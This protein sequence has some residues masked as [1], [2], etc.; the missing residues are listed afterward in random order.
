MT[1]QDDYAAQVADLMGNAFEALGKGLGRLP[2][3]GREELILEAQFQM[4]AAQA[5][6]SLASAAEARVQSLIQMAA[7][8]SVA[9]DKPDPVIA[10]EA[11]GAAAVLLGLAELEDGQS[12]EDLRAALGLDDDAKDA[13]LGD[14][15]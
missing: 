1:K 9:G 6:A 15:P 4:G 10:Q 5:L 12:L 14:L 13:E 7:L 2:G 3:D 11:Y 8:E